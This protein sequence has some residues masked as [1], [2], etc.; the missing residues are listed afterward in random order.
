[1]ILLNWQTASEMNNDHFVVERSADGEN[2]EELFSVTGKR[3]S[4]ET[5]DYFGIDRYPFP[6][7]NY[8]RL[9]QVD[10][11]GHTE[12][13]KTTAC[14]VP[15]DTEPLQLQVF[16]LSGKL[17]HSAM[18]EKA[19]VMLKLSSLSFIPGVY[20]VVCT[21]GNGDMHAFKYLKAE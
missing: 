13:L 1:M 5:S 9:K 18:V 16:D 21:S 12:I 14:E 11:D 7:T 6:S 20:L 8:Y 15:A 10:V 3:F 19:D 2:F 17:L 4:S